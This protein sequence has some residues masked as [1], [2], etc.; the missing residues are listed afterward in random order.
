MARLASQQVE[1]MPEQLI[2]VPPA[3]EAPEIT[4]LDRTCVPNLPCPWQPESLPR[5][6]RLVPP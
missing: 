4:R 3:T 1:Y 2:R 5:S 6:T